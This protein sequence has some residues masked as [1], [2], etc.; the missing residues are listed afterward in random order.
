M[1]ITVT[2][3]AL[4]V[5]GL[6][7]LSPSDFPLITTDPSPARVGQVSPHGRHGP[8]RRYLPRGTTSRAAK[9]GQAGVGNMIAAD[10]KKIGQAP[11]R[12]TEHMPGLSCLLTE[13]QKSE[14]FPCLP[15]PGDS[16]L[17]LLDTETAFD[18]PT[19]DGQAPKMAKL[20]GDEMASADAHPLAITHPPLMAFSGSET[21]TRHC[22]STPSHGLTG[23]NQK[24]IQTAIN[25]CL[26]IMPWAPCLR[27]LPHP[28]AFG[29]A[30]AESPAA[31]GSYLGNPLGQEC[32]R[33]LL[34]HGAR[35]A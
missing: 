2:M 35:D 20:A 16:S 30:P 12:G 27:M 8:L 10:R 14:H 34:D 31:A 6:S 24:Q 29:C 32:C 21:R 13:E 19:G 7:L 17:Y 26:V 28:C 11:A 23:P 9:P 1:L 18:R 4:S 25:L 33:T 15:L 3:P 5:P 22:L